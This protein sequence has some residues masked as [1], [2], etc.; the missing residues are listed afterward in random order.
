VTTS[1]LENKRKT[2]TSDVPATVRTLR[3]FVLGL[4]VIGILGTGADLLLTG[5]FEDWWQLT[6]LIVVAL[7]ALTLIGHA[8]RPSRSTIRA[9]QGVMM[10]FIL[11][12][13]IGTFLHY[14][15]N[16][17]FELE[18]YPGMAGTELLWKAIQGASPPSLAPGA[19]IALGLLGLIYAYKHPAI[20]AGHHDRTGAL[21]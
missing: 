15:A 7:S 12:G 2:P 6:P 19:M 18:M 17:E 5:H 9:H 1:S 21:P 4:F 13:V 20:T 16:I 11:S 3:R 8:F 14:R 10:L